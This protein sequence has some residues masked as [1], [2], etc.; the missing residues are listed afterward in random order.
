LETNPA[1]FEKSNPKEI[2]HA[3]PSRGESGV[4]QP[5]EKSE[6]PRAFK[7]DRLCGAQFLVRACAAEVSVWAVFRN[8]TKKTSKASVR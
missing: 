2:R 6:D 4:L 5:L 3:T 7:V 8:P 1:V